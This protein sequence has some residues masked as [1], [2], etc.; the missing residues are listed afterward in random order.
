[1]AAK[2]KKK[3]STTLIEQDE[4][5]VAL[6]ERWFKLAKQ[7]VYPKTPQITN[8]LDKLEVAITKRKEEIL[9]EN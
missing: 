2:K 9:N 8:T 1:M 5:L 3:D 4:T 7:E 6:K